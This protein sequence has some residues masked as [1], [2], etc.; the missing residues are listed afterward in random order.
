MPGSLPRAGVVA[1]GLLGAQGLAEGWALAA[2][3]LHH[4]PDARLLVLPACIP[5]LLKGVAAAVVMGLIGAQRP[6]GAALSSAAVAA[7]TP[8]AALAALS[9]HS[10]SETEAFDAQDV[11]GK[12]TAAVAGASLVVALQVL[13]PIAVLVQR[14]G[15]IR[16]LA[17]GVLCA[18]TLYAT[19][20][21]F[22][23]SSGLCLALQ[24]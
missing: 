17:S 11:T 22:C 23:S 4:L 21:F 9:H 19:L 8:V 12:V 7:S 24:Q 2:A 20:N 18:V 15:A 5:A 14:G 3:A 1:V 6:L 10:S 16:G 13:L